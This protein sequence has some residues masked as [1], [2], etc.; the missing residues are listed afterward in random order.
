MKISKSLQSAA[1]AILI[2][3][4]FFQT[5]CRAAREVMRENVH[6]VDRGFYEYYSQKLGYTLSGTEN[7]ALIKEIEAWLG[8]PHRMGGNSKQG[9]DCSGFV[10]EV[11][12]AVYSVN[13]PRTSAAMALFSMEINQAELREG[14]L[15]FFITRK[16]S[17]INHVGIYVSDG[18]FV[19]VSST[20]LS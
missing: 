7:P 3:I 6:E 9:A 8:T 19:H 13:L 18:R 17:K 16:G 11:F 15:V 5:G 14:D 20:L 2:A 12:R 4:S 1:M 10:G